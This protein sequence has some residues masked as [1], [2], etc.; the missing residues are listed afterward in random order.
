MAINHNTNN[1]FLQI[2]FMNN[3]FYYLSFSINN[4]PLSPNNF[5]TVIGN[6]TPDML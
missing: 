1:L 3:N 5:P 6:T 2:F 4:I